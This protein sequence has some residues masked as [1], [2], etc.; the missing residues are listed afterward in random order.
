MKNKELEVEVSG[1]VQ[2]I[3][4]RQL[5]RR[6]AS[7]EG[8][9]GFVTNR[10]D[11]RVYILAQGPEN[12]LQQFLKWISTH[13]GFSKIQSLHYTWR[14]S[15]T[16]YGSFSITHTD[17]FLK[18]QMRNFINL[19]KS[20]LKKSS[21]VPGH[22]VIIPDGNRRWAKK[23]GLASEMGHY[24]AGSI[25]NIKSLIREADALGVKYLSVWGFST[26]NWKRASHEVRA[27]FDLVGE[28]L[29]PLIEESQKNNMRFRHV[30]RSDRLP[31]KLLQALQDAEE[32]T[33]NNT[34]IM[35]VLCLDYGGRD[36]ILHALNQALRSGKKQVSETEFRNYLYTSDIPDPDLIIRTSGEQRI[37][38]FMPFQAA[39]AEL[40]FTEKYFPEFGAADLCK[41]VDE[42]G[43]RQ[44]RFGGS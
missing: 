10:D 26:E 41:A 37:S 9:T 43:R 27:I 12:K 33:K 16:V 3:G 34:G 22:V 44:R 38:G 19:G 23:R 1:R 5:V 2:G 35:L 15:L 32:K 14:A 18:E 25:T 28:A 20:L 7:R 11:G 30:G 21:T 42:F 4:F 6:W 13:P 36:E 39:Y 29:V 40:Y 24:K 17:S 8:I 31:K